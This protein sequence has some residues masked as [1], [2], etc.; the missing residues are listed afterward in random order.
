MCPFIASTLDCLAR[1]TV[2]SHFLHTLLRHCFGTSLAKT[3]PLMAA[4][5][6]PAVTR[7]IGARRRLLVVERGAALLVSEQAES[8]KFDET[9]TIAQMR[10]ESPD[11]FSDRVVRRIGAA[12]RSIPFG[13][14]VLYASGG[15][16]EATFSARRLIALAT[17]GQAE[18]TGSSAEM[19]V[20]ASASA[21]FAERERLLELADDLIFGT[22][23]ASLPVRLRFI[24]G[25]V[26]GARFAALAKVDP[27]PER[28][29]APA[30]RRALAG[31]GDD[32]GL[33]GR[34]ASC[35]RL[36]AQS[37]AAARATSA[38]PSAR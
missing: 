11:D 5:S 3:P 30:H 28:R 21:S 34:A 29:P 32:P 17:A 31:Q 14:V 26:H 38:T 4:P 16:E 7:L 23:G 15:C 1:T 25:A 13:E 8:E 22:H 33:E 10:D 19:V 6:R 20:V 27:G 24:A 36:A 35:G 37:H 12:A 2:R 18:V 9:V